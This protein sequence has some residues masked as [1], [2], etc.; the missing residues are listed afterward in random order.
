MKLNDLNN[1]LNQLFKS[2][3]FMCFHHYFTYTCMHIILTVKNMRR[4]W[5][6]FA[7]S[8]TACLGLLL[9]L[10]LFYPHLLATSQEPITIKQV[11]PSLI[12]NNISPK[13]SYSS[14]AKKA[15]P[16]VVNIFTSSQKVAV[17]PHHHLIDHQ[18]NV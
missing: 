17:N 8:V 18:K 14:A 1:Y 3:N 16:A 7:Q 4:I 12:A 15:M 13:S 2:F 6:I 10:R 9:V 11:Q 5:L